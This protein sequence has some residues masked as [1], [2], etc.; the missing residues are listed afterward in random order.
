MITEN[1][2]KVYRFKLDHNL[3]F[4]FAEVYD[5]TDYSTFDGRVVYVFNRLDKE[6]KSGYDILEIGK[7]GIA[8]GPIRLH[9]FPNTRGVHAWKFILKNE[10]FLITELPETK[11]LQ[12]LRSNDDNWNN[13]KLKWYNS[14]Y[15]KQKL[16][17]YVDYAEVRHLETRIIN[18]PS[19]V[20]TK[21]T[22]KVIIDN[23]EQVSK[24][25]DLSDLGT[26]NMFVQMI[27]TYYPLIRTK[28]LLKQLPGKGS[29]DGG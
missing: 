16:P 25:Y 22:M 23:N 12:A 4:G 18:P 10:N 20:V 7:T 9:K 28:E 2:G 21:F 19:G 24:Y 5:F 1:S 14:N 8:I 27:N 11:E 15:D 6:E 3:G 17:D 13:F 26:K 29:T